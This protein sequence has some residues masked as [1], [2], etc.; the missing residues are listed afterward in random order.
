MKINKIKITN[1][2]SIYGTQEFDFNEL[3]GMIK[4]SGPIGSGKTSL[5]E[6]ILFGLYGTIKDHKNPNLIAW[7]TKDYKVCLLYTS[8]CV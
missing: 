6:A 5:L 8:R 7:N 4:L 1:F 2:K 3:N